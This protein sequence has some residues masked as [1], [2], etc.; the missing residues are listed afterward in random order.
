[1]RWTKIRA[2]SPVKKLVMF[3][4]LERADGSGSISIDQDT[5]ARGAE[6]TRR[7]IARALA[8]LERDGLIKRF[9]RYQTDGPNKGKRSEDLIVLN[10]DREDRSDWARYQR[11]LVD[12][13]R[14]SLRIATRR[15]VFERD[16]HACTE[17]GSA[18]RLEV[19]HM[20]PTSRGGSDEPD[21]LQAL[22][23]PCNGSKGAKTMAE[24]HAWKAGR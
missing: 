1:M 23:Q 17:C 6:A 14:A 12:G 5:L 20:L 2:G 24:W 16:G 8:S 9:P 7:T 15:Y 4:L 21:N 19:D 11:D 22:C 18:Q 13:C 10:V 3:L